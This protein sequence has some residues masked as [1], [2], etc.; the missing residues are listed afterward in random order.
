MGAKGRA[1]C[2]AARKLAETIWRLF[3]LG[4]CFDAARAFGGRA[5]V[6]A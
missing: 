6:T 5:R 3:H 1:R 2:A 4:E